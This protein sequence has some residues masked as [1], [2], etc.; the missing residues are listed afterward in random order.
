MFTFRSKAEKQF[1]SEAAARKYLKYANTPED[2]KC[3]AGEGYCMIYGYDIE[4]GIEF[5][6]YYLKSVLWLEFLFDHPVL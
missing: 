2:I 3:S 1:E 4:N 6:E 5:R